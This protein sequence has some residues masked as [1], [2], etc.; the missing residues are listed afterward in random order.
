MTN[1]TSKL[2]HSRALSKSSAGSTGKLNKNKSMQRALKNLMKDNTANNDLSMVDSRVKE[3]VRQL[4]QDSANNMKEVNEML[5]QEM[6]ALRAQVFE[7]NAA[8]ENERVLRQSREERLME[9]ED[10]SAVLEQKFAD[11]ED[12]I[13]AKDQTIRSLEAQVDFLKSTKRAASISPKRREQSAEMRELRRQKGETDEINRQI[14]G[15]IGILK[16][17]IQG[18]QNQEKFNKKLLMAQ[19]KKDREL[20]EMQEQ[21]KQVQQQTISNTQDRRSPHSRTHLSS[22][23]PTTYGH[24]Q[25]TVGTLDS[26]RATK[27]QSDMLQD[28]RAQLEHLQRQK[29]QYR[30]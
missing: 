24:T 13:I 8:L 9:V 15:Q 6:E 18:F 20:K 11:L 17:A 3:K 12:R 25:N 27:N 23:Y 5:H 21:I 30:D 22:S 4:Q 16:D 1:D 2:S 28:M 7:A 14:L 10:G 29:D 26:Q 19:K